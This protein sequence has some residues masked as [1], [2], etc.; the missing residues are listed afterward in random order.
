MRKL[1]ITLYI[2]ANLDCQGQKVFYFKEFSKDS[3]EAIEK[4]FISAI[5]SRKEMVSA[6]PEGHEE[7]L[8]HWTDLHATFQK[9]LQDHKFLFEADTKFFLRF[10]FNKDGTIARVG[11]NLK[12]SMEKDTRLKFENHLTSFSSIHN[13]GMK[14]QQPYAQCGSVTYTK[15][16]NQ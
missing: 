4:N 8:Q 12:E 5:D 3:V 1:F 9:Y 15:N 10:Y 14:A 6:F 13:F 2:V 16:N 11:Y 7:V